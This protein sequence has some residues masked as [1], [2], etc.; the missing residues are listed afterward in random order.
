MPVSA[1]RDS[2][3]QRAISRSSSSNCRPKKR[4]RQRSSRC[5]CARVSAIVWR[6]IR[7]PGPPEQQK[8]PSQGGNQV[9]DR[10]AVFAL[11]RA[12]AREEQSAVAAQVVNTER[13]G[14]HLVA[15]R[16]IGI[17]VPRIGVYRTTELLPQRRAA[18]GGHVVRV[19]LFQNKQFVSHLSV[20][21]LAIRTRI[22]AAASGTQ[23]RPSVS[24]T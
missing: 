3:R 13:R 16:H 18:V 7:R 6:S 19:L 17:P 4:S 14:A 5:R 22:V 2:L 21:R 8:P 15:L 11:R 23:V 1:S 20:A 9:G 10:V 24:C 12:I